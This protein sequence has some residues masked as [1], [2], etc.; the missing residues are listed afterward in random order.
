MGTSNP[1]GE[2]THVVVMEQ[3][4]DVIL[5]VLEIYP[6][7]CSGCVTDLHIKEDWTN[8]LGGDLRSSSAL[9]VLQ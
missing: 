2:H 6:D 3:S 9:L 7:I 4:F 5:I 1:L 8:G